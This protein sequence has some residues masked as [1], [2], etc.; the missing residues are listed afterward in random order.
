MIINN[1]GDEEAA[2]V[3]GARSGRGHP[4]GRA[5][6]GEEDEGDE[7]AAL[8]RRHYRCRP[9]HGGC[10][11]CRCLCRRQTALDRRMGGECRKC[12]GRLRT[13]FEQRHDKH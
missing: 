4:G 2:P 12:K 8:V 5:G 10:H 13:G 9:C 6:A 3:G 1:K 11:P 7:E